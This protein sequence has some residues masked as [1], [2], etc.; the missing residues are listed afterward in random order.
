MRRVLLVVCLALPAPAGAAGA[1]IRPAGAD[2]LVVYAADSPDR[3]GSGTPDGLEA[4]EYYAKR[5]AVPAENLLPV[6]TQRRPGAKG[7]WT[8]AEFFARILQPVAK[9]LAAKTA[10]GETFSRRICYILLGPHVPV[11]MLTHPKPKQPERSWFRKSRRRSVDGYL[12]R[13]AENLRAGF[14]EKSASAGPGQAGPIGSTPAEILLPVYGAFGPPPRAA[15]FRQLRRRQP[16]RFGFYLVARLGR[17][18]PSARDMLDGALYAERHLRLPADGEAGPAIWLDQKYRFA[19]DHVAAMSR[20]VPLVRGV[21]GSAFAGGKGLSKAWPVVI[22]NQLAE[23]GSGDPAHKPTV[24]AVIASDGVDAKGVT[25]TTRRKISRRGR[26]AATVLYFPPGC[27]VG[28]FEPP[29]KPPKPRP[30]ATGPAGSQTRPAKPP[31]APAPPKLLATAKVVGFDE[32]DNRLLLDSTAGFQA[33]CTVRYVWPGEFPAR[34]CFLFY[35]FYGLGRYEDVFQFLPGAIGVHVDSSCMRWAHG[36]VGRGIAATF[37]V[38]AEPLSA[39]IPYGDGMLVALAAGAGWA[40]AAYGSL[41]L[42]QRWTG[43]V[44]GDPLYAPFRSQLL[45]DKTPPVLGKAQARADGRGA[46]T[47][48]AALAGRTA[49]ERADVALFRVDFGRSKRYGQRVDF[50]DW[51]Q[52][53]T[54]R[55]VRGRR[56]GYSRHFRHT[57]KGLEKGATYHYR[58]VARDPAGQEAATPDATFIP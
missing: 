39:G 14:D 46:V 29:P 51:P 54:G 4:A 48:T 43:V 1:D 15:T 45:A 23:I 5:R 49:D 24:E 12:I 38:T 47:I 41:R 9:K 44:F 18:L 13:I 11:S 40:E 30:A 10:A 34:R 6:S 27:T 21:K 17:D 42:A 19:G 58:L 57:L 52:P 20:A 16:E 7:L 3:D 28:C 31:P 55:G 32:A 50:F 36:A 2:V 26:D 35:G 56:F 53:Q 8:Y 37:G 25:L 33:G 22:D